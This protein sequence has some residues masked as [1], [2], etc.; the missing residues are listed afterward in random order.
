MLKCAMAKNRNAGIGLECHFRK[1][2]AMKET[3]LSDEL[4]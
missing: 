4:K 2:L 1:T 3:P